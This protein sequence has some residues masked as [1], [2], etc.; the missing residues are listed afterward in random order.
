MQAKGTNIESLIGLEFKRN[1]YGL[2]SW[3]DKIRYVGYKWS[4]VDRKKRM[5]VMYIMGENSSVHFS[6]DEIVVV[7]KPFNKIEELKF[8]K[9]EIQEVISSGGDLGEYAKKHNIKFVQPLDI[10][11]TNKEDK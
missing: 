2:S 7:N 10:E 9:R 6:L 1:K 11:K 3:T 8:Q 4:H 5:I